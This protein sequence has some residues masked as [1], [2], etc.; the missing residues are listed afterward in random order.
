MNT[1]NTINLIGRIREKSNKFLLKKL[2]F[3]IM[4]GQQLNTVELME[5]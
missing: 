1:D 5:K 3:I 4:R 2:N